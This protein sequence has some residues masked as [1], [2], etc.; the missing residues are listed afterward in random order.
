MQEGKNYENMRVE[1][2]ALR[3]L[4]AG[5][6]L[7]VIGSVHDSCQV[8]ERADGLVQILQKGVQIP[9]LVGSLLYLVG[10]ILNIREQ[11]PRIH[12]SLQLLVNAYMLLHLKRC[13]V[14]LHAYNI[15]VEC[16]VLIG[17]ALGVVWDM[18]KLPVPGGRIGECG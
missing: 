12:H 10:G 14:Y 4:V 17:V 3:L 1:K 7:W 11:V 5:P 8:Y 2:H 9:F 16:V 18:G 15:C 6:A 13:N